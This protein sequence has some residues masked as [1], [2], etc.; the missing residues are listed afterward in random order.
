MTASRVLQVGAEPSRAVT[1]VGCRLNI[2]YG[3]DGSGVVA[4]LLASHWADDHHL[5][6]WQDAAA[7]AGDR[8]WRQHPDLLEKLTR[9]M[10]SGDNRAS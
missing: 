5:L 8:L 2:L 10:E 1:C 9:M 7:D 4:D 3:D 6:G